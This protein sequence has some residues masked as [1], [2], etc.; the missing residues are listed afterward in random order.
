[1][2]R[3]KRSHSKAFK[4]RIVN[5]YLY[6]EKSQRE[7]GEE[8]GLHPAMISRWVRTFIRDQEESFPGSGHQKRS[9]QEERHQEKKIADLELENEIL[10]KYLPSS[11]IS[12][13]EICVYAILLK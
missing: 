13:N 4:L 6:G 12:R 7:L 3:M 2:V 1:M 5:A 9:K 8:Y 11:P 10:K